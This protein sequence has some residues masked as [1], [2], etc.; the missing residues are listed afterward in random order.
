MTSRAV[1]LT[2]VLILLVDAAAG[3]AK[4]T[5]SIEPGKSP[6]ELE[7]VANPLTQAWGDPTLYAAGLSADADPA[8]A[9]LADATEYHLDLVLDGDLTGLSGQLALRYTN[10]LLVPLPALYFRLFPNISGGELEIEQINVGRTPVQG[11]LES[12]GSV[13]KVE[14]PEHLPPGEALLLEASFRLGLPLEMAGNYGLFGYHGGILL[15]QEFMPLLPVVDEDGWALE[16]P[17]V[18]GDLTHLPAAFFLV[19]IQ[20]PS[21]LVVASSG[22]ILERSVSGGEQM[23]LMAAGPARDFYLAASDK[24]TQYTLEG[25]GVRLSNFV[26]GADPATAEEMLTIASSAI[27]IFSDLLGAYPYAEF[28][29]IGTPMQA[30]GMEYP[31]IVALVDQLYDPQATISGLP[32]HVYVEATVVHEVAHQWFYN[33]IGNDQV[34]YPWLDEAMAQYATGLYFRERYGERGY[35]GF[36][37][38]WL[39]RWD[40]V[41][42]VDKP[43]GLP[44]AEYDGKEYGAI[45]YG[46]GP[47]FVET[48]AQTMGEA[49]FM[50]FL[51]AYG[52]QLRW[53]IV[54]PQKFL[55]LAEGACQCDLDELFDMWVFKQ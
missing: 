16:T 49:S 7:V 26:S 3:C 42:R 38:S 18:H 54:T 20:A 53:E 23:L 51:H 33:L 48:L 4:A 10:P 9:L 52:A 21:E 29:M 37:D 1:L 46:R 30:L 19:R 22:S 47:L 8:L 45:V 50:G 43:I 24:F 5:G 13:Y 6:V 41:E 12:D 17:P 55:E 15:L 25:A 36:R 27:S 14:L 39:A 40:R 31:G 28:D 44:S 11:V 34:M 32:A 35:E 2:I